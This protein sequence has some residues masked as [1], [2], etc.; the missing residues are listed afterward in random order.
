M[1]GNTLPARDVPNDFFTTD[2]ITTL[3][4]ID[5]KII[6]TFYLKFGIASQPKNPLNN[7]GNSRL[8]FRRRFLQFFRSETGN[9][10]FGGNLAVADR[11]E[12][13][14]DRGRAVIR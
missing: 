13:I 1:Y 14:L 12:Q 7:R 6:E 9:N 11:R 8:F 3:C 10:L 5:K 4:A 2:G